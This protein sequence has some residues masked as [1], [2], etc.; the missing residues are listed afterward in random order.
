MATPSRSIDPTA[1]PRSTG[2]DRWLAVALGLLLAVLAALMVYSASGYGIGLLPDSMDYLEAARSLL[3]GEGLSRG[4][5]PLTHFP[6][7]YP[8]LLAAAGRL[9]GELI[10][11][12]RLL[13]CLL[14]AVTVLAVGVTAWTASGRSLAAAALAM[15]ASLVFTGLVHLHLIALSEPAFFGLALLALLALARYLGSPTPLSMLGC[16]AAIA[17]AILTRYAGLA[18]V[19]SALVSILLLDRRPTWQRIRSAGL[20]AALSVSPL[21]LWLVRNAAVAASATNRSL[22]FHPPDLE[23]LKT[24][25][26]TVS[27]WAFPAP[28]LAPG[29][30]AVVAM[31]FAATMVATVVLGFGALRSGEHGGRPRQ[32]LAAVLGIFAIC[33]G[34]FLLLSRSFAD[35]HTNFDNRILA[36]VLITTLILAAAVLRERR[37]WT[38][39]RRGAWWILCAVWLLAAVA[40]IPSTRAVL[41]EGRQRG[42]GYADVGWRGSGTLAVVRQM[43]RNLG[44]YSNAPEVIRVILDRPAEM[45]PRF[46]STSTGRDNPGYERQLGRMMADIN[47]GR[48]ILVFF[49]RMRSRDYLPTPEDLVESHGLELVLQAQ[50]GAIYGARP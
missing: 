19:I 18:I 26:Y 28:V 14:I 23:A 17:A 38:S 29:M 50:D 9:D 2:G 11:A 42:F 20:V 21:L 4:G 5:E 37:R 36:P 24:L 40:N 12:A 35:A 6:P 41:L 49:D 27:F 46:R 31:A 30:R 3:R 33:Y 8:L 13:H 25:A 10:A 7:L 44:L 16:A 47:A 1:D 43:P 48:S 32:P 39:G 15:A 22:A 45:L 34:L